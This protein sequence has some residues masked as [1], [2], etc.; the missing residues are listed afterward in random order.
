MNTSRNG[1]IARLPADLRHQLNRRLADA[2]PGDSLLN[3]LNALPEVQAILATQFH[4]API[5]KQNLSE[6]R[7]GGFLAWQIRE[8]FRAETQDLIADAAQ[9]AQVTTTGDGTRLSDHLATVLSGRYAALLVNWD[10]EVTAP[11]TLKLRALSSLS[12]AIAELRRSEESL[13][14]RQKTLADSGENAAPRP[15]SPATIPGQS[16]PVKPSQTNPSVLPTEKPSP[17]PESPAEP[18]SVSPNPGKIV[19]LPGLLAKTGDFLPM[20]SPKFLKPHPAYPPQPQLPPQLA[21][22]V[23]LPNPDDYSF[24]PAPALT[25]RPAH[26][27]ELART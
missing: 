17:K 19:P 25:T 8:E 26:P 10:G 14:R 16:D 27:R 24:L 1:K 7:A 21:P 22:Q 15:S 23:I 3:W 12:R 9:L 2:E 4:G 6:W 5:S 13:A 11:F 20:L 18:D